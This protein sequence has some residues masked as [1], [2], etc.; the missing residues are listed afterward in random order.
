MKKS[1]F[2]LAIVWSILAG[3]TGALAE[4]VVVNEVMYNPR[5]GEPEWIELANITATP[6]DIADWKLRGSV[7][8][9]FPAFDEA[10]ARASFLGHWQKIILT[11]I[12]AGQFESSSVSRRA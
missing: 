8:M 6:F 12:D 7:E 9:D 1:F 11:S 10:D 2:T 3:T 4:Q 5:A